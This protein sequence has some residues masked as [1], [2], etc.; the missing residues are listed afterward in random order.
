VAGEEGDRLAAN[1]KGGDVGVEIDAIEALK[2][3][4]APAASAIRSARACVK[5]N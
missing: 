3:G 2:I 5:M 1:L 4:S